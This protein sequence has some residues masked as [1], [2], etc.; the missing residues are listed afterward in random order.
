MID[1]SFAISRMYNDNYIA[2]VSG[3]ITDMVTI[4]ARGYGDL[5]EYSTDIDTFYFE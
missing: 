2:V 3:D 5:L 4:I 1:T